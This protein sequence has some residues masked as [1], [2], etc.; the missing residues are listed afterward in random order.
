MLVSELKSKIDRFPRIKLLWGNTPIVKAENLSRELGVDLYIK[1]DDLSGLALG[2]NKTRKLEFI[3]GEALAQKCDTVI[4]AGAVHSNHALQT[5]AAAKKLG[6]D[7]V[8]VLRGKEKNK[9]NLLMDK[10]LDADVK[11]YDVPTSD[12]LKDHMEEIAAKLVSQGKK[13]MIIPVGGSNP[14]GVL[15]YING[16]VEIVEQLD[17]MKINLDY[18]VS[19]TSSGGTQAGILLGF[20]LLKPQ[21]QA[22]GIGVGDPR[23]ELLQ[24]VAAL[25]KGTAE[26]L[27]VDKNIISLEELEEK[28]IDGYGFGSYGAIAKEVIDLIRYVAK[29]EGF[30][31]DPV[32]TGKC[33]YG[34][35]DMIKK[36]VIPKGAGVLFVHTGGLGG[37]FQ[38]EEVVSEMIK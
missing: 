31:V 16:A 15:G 7:A 2:G 14:T 18:V 29:N 33:L 26:V 36:G 19:S 27:G 17:E 32:Y 11:I 23:Q 20:K 6:L 10:L 35:I 12:A 28:T 21:V 1:R 30:Y 9:G 8:L 37:I 22:L 5:A 13:P 34:L 4:T 25:V 3:M 38:Y 24:D